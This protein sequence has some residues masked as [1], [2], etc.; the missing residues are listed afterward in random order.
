M[1]DEGEF[2]SIIDYAVDGP[3]TQRELIRLFAGLQERWVRYY[4]G[5]QEATFFASVNGDRVYSVVRWD[6]EA[7]YRRFEEDSDSDGS[8]AAIQASL[9]G[10]SGRAEPRMSGPPLFRV[11][12]V[13]RP[14]PRQYTD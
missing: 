3:A 9:A 7:H 14:G 2:Y 4:A 6:S 5:Y 11:A 8:V 13:V 12:R 1:D 10:L